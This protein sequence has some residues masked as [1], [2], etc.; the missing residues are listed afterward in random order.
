VEGTELLRCTHRIA[1]LRIGCTSALVLLT[2]AGCSNIPPAYNPIEW[3]NSARH[4]VAGWFESNPSESTAHV[5]PP[6]AEGRPYPNLATVPKPPPRETPESRAERQRQIAA[7]S[8]DRNTA[9]ANDT[10]LRTTGE[11][12]APGMGAAPPEAA[13]IAPRSAV[14]AGAQAAT[15]TATAAPAAPSALTTSERRG[16]VAFG[17]D[18]ERLTGAAEGTLHDAALFALA[19][20]G[21]VRVVP[22]QIARAAEFPQATQRRRQA[23]VQALTSAGLPADRVAVADGGAQ[24]VEVYDV[25]VDE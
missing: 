15:T 23:I 14:P 25:Y 22:A 24:R 7:L 21:R 3:V 12:P 9:I 17:R 18:G 2:V 1:K 10:T 13:A 20:G 6:P 11:M 19:H 16:S 5:E 4:E 8:A